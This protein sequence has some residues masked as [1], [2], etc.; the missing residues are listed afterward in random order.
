MELVV[1]VRDRNISWIMVLV[2]P[3]DDRDAASSLPESLL[4]TSDMV[5][6]V[7]DAESGSV[8]GMNFCMLLHEDVTYTFPELSTAT[9]WGHLSVPHF[10]RNCPSE[11]NFWMRSLPA[12]ATY[13]FP[14]SSTAIPR[15]TENWPSSLPRD[16]HWSSQTYYSGVSWL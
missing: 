14:E 11:L 16:P 9:P 4:L 12:S 3:A 13:T 7:G 2:V 1:S 6:G 10:V 5:N 15:G 8:Q